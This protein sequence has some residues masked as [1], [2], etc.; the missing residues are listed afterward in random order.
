MRR[1]AAA[2][3]ALARAGI[4]CAARDRGEPGGGRAALE[5][6]PGTPLSRARGLRRHDWI[7]R[8]ATRSTPPR[9]AGWVLNDAHPGNAL[10]GV[11]G[12]R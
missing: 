11:I 12:S 3:D 1:E 10:V 2:L 4:R 7:A 6:V 9:R 5:H 8:I